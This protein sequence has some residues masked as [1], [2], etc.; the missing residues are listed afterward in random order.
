MLISGAV[1][2]RC[3]ML[4]YWLITERQRRLIRCLG[5][6]RVSQIFIWVQNLPCKH[7]R[8]VNTRVHP[9]VLGLQ[10]REREGTLCRCHFV[11]PL[12]S[13]TLSL[14]LHSPSSSLVWPISRLAVTNPPPPRLRLGSPQVHTLQW[15]RNISY[16]T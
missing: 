2:V 1:R 9:H 10:D 7:K 6:E 3:E 11:S 15:T 14:F 5:G 4:P 8:C 12:V 13:L 16:S